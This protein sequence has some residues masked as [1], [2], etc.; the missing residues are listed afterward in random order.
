MNEEMVKT[1]MESRGEQEALKEDSI[2]GKIYNLA[3]EEVKKTD[4]LID[5]RRTSER[6]GGVYV[7]DYTNKLSGRFSVWCNEPGMVTFVVPTVLADKL[8]ADVEPTFTASATKNYKVDMDSS[9]DVVRKL[10]SSIADL[11]KE[12]T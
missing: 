3:V 6:F 5:V 7:V 9:Y 10:I 12:N 1:I 11:H 8:F 2:L 4:L